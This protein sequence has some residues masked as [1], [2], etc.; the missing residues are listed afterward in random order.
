MEASAATLVAAEQS[1]FHCLTVY[2]EWRT[3]AGQSLQLK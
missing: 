3:K 2:E 1:R